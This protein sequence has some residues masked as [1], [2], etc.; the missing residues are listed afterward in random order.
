M[1]FAK[2]EKMTNILIDCGYINLPR[3]HRPRVVFREHLELLVMSA[4]Y[5]FGT[6]AAF[7]SC[8]LL[9]GISTSEVCKFFN[10]FI[11]A[12]VDMKDEYIYLPRNITKSQ[13]VNTDYNAVHDCQ[14]VLVPWTWSM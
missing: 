4:L 2:V 1:P 13:C 10:T 3:S 6:G 11:E 7:R 9:C 14:V 8:K 12:L 5:L